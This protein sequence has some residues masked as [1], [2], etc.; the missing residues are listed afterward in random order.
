LGGASVAVWVGRDGVVERLLL[1]FAMGMGWFL[2]VWAIGGL[3]VLGPGYG[4]AD[5][6][7]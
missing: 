7:A 4:E 3:L 6:C 1:S 5:G 2:F